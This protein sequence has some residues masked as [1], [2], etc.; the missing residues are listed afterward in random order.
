MINESYSWKKELHRSYIDIVKFSFK[1]NRNDRDYVVLEK[2]L[3]MGAYICRKL[4]ESEKLPPQFLKSREAIKTSKVLDGKI[5][6]GLN[7]H[8]VDKN[9][10]LSKSLQIE[11]D[12]EFILNQLIHSFVIFYILNDKDELDCL[13]INS[14]YSKDKEIL[15]IPIGIIYKIFLSIS[16]GTLVE[17][18]TEREYL[19]LT[20]DGKPKFGKM[21]YNKGVYAYPKRFEINKI[22]TGSLLG[23]IYKKKGL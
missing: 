11:K 12:W 22:V 14:T 18:K 16:C 10:N 8:K 15:L 21:V 7:S 9:Y 13:L 4:H 3:M 23:N 1:K 20:D 5:V 6:D 2:S 19:G 17:K